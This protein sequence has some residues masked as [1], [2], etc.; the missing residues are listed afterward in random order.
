MQ[1][2][3]I[4]TDYKLAE[5]RHLPWTPHMWECGRNVCSNGESNQSGRERKKKKIVK[6]KQIAHDV[7]AAAAAAAAHPDEE[8]ISLARVSMSSKR[9]EKIANQ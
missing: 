4:S 7:A 3:H 2:A 5:N 1:I 9:I 8:K 6:Q